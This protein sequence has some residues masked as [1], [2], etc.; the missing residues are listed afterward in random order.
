[1]ADEPAHGPAEQVGLGGGEEQRPATGLDRDALIL[2]GGEDR[3]E[4]HPTPAEDRDVPVRIAQLVVEASDRLRDDPKPFAC[5][6]MAG[7]ERRFFVMLKRLTIL[8]R[9][10]NVTMLDTSEPRH[11]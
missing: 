11:W 3:L 1:V 10:S 9:V 7:R 5:L 6:M 4:G 8:Y 2:Q